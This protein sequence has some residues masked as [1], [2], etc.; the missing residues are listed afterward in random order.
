MKIKELIFAAA[1]CTL[2]GCAPKTDATRSEA[3]TQSSE[4]TDSTR[5]PDNMELWT[6]QAVNKAVQARL[7]S[8]YADVFARYSKAETDPSVLNQNPDFESRY[9]SASYNELFRKVNALD[10]RLAEKG[11]V[12]FFDYDHWV[13]GQ[14]FQGL[15]MR[16][17]SG[18][19]QGDERYDAQ[20]VVRNCGTDH[21]ML[22][23]LVFENGEWKID[24]LRTDGAALSEKDAMARYVERKTCNCQP[25]KKGNYGIDKRKAQKGVWRTPR[26]CCS[27]LPPSEAVSAHGWG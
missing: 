24:D 4:T 12:S 13:C 16:V 26:R 19:W 23:R 9:M 17:V 15:S 7:R 5:L 27:C 25:V 1:I 18:K 21:R 11:L 20:I 10:E 8:I 14:D 2:A 3:Q 22:V 6:E